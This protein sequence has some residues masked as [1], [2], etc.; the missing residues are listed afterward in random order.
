MNRITRTA[1]LA[2]FGLALVGAT[3]ARAD[4][5]TFSSIIQAQSGV[6][7]IGDPAV[8]NEAGGLVNDARSALA[9]N[10]S[11]SARALA[12]EALALIEADRGV[13][14]AAR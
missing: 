10:D 7:G 2:L 9:D 11:A 13:D 4:G 14:V 12:Q 5:L 6:A 3:D 8:R 1:A